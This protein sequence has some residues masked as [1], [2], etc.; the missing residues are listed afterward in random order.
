MIHALI[1]DSRGH[2]ATRNFTDMEALTRW[3]AAQKRLHRGLTLAAATL[4]ETPSLYELEARAREYV[5]RITHCPKGFQWT[6]P[7][8]GA[9]YFETR[10][11]A[12]RDAFECGELGE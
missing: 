12:L 10:P 1:S 6:S 4:T 3:N 7:K 8:D 11:A 9:G 5:V 2:T